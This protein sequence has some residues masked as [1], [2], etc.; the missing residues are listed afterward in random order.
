MHSPP[1]ACESDWPLCMCLG[2]VPEI[3]WVLLTWQSH[4]S[5]C[6]RNKGGLLCSIR[7]PW[8]DRKTRTVGTRKVFFLITFRK[9]DAVIC[10]RLDIPSSEHEGF[11]PFLQDCRTARANSAPN[12]EYVVKHDKSKLQRTCIPTEGN[13][14]EANFPVSLIEWHWG[15]SAIHRDGT[16]KWHKGWWSGYNGATLKARITQAV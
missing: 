16:Y 3:S 12:V 10:I 7:Y 14:G 13:Q 8:K 4:G 11:W 1:V 6:L 5:L 9:S 15:D 2:C